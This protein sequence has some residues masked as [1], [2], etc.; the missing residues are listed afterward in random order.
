MTISKEQIEQDKKYFQNR[1]ELPSTATVLEY[2]LE[3][4][5]LQAE[6]ERLQGMAMGAER[7]REEVRVLQAELKECRKNS[8]EVAIEIVQSLGDGSEMQDSI[9]NALDGLAKEAR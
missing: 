3:V 1:S 2:V 7:A 8:F 9:V 6:V 5:R 4:E